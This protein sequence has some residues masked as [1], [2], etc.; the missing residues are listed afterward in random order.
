MAS[1]NQTKYKL[2]EFLLDVLLNVIGQRKIMRYF[3]IS[4]VDIRRSL[5]RSIKLANAPISGLPNSWSR[6]FKFKAL[7][8][9]R[10]NDLIHSHYYLTKSRHFNSSHL[11]WKPANTKTIFFRNIFVLQGCIIIF[12]ILHTAFIQSRCTEASETLN[13][14]ANKLF[15]KRLCTNLIHTPRKNY[16]K[17]AWWCINISI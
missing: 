3:Q 5:R 12:I 10:T 4:Y 14:V 7:I 15:T 2:T 16:V 13:L 9:S 8:N 11:A 6:P 1:A 17:N